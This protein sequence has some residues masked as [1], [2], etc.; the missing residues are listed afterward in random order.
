M[1][2]LEECGPVPTKERNALAE[3]VHACCIQMYYMKSQA[4]MNVGD[5]INFDLREMLVI[6][7]FYK[8]TDSELKCAGRVA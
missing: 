5:V 6:V 1:R 8:R 3:K 4:V 2:P 7:H